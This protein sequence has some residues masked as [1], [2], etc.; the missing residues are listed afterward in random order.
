[1]CIANATY[2]IDSVPQMY[3][4]KRTLWQFFFYKCF[5]F[6]QNVVI[7]VK[8]L[9]QRFVHRLDRETG[10]CARERQYRPSFGWI[11]L[12]PLL[13]PRPSVIHV[14]IME[15]FVKLW[16]NEID[17]IRV[18]EGTER[19]PLLRVAGRSVT[20]HTGLVTESWRKDKEFILLSEELT[21]ALTY[22]TFKRIIRAYISFF[23]VAISSARHPS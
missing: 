2:P 18:P 8:A 20:P 12:L 1:M 6:I 4:D 19:I 5:R 10:G 9:L 21:L 16:F 23:Q 17:I 7:P 22:L 13:L 11:I 15:R 14:V 3:A